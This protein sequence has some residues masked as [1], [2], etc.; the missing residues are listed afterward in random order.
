[1]INIQKNLE[2]L[3]KEKRVLRKQVATALGVSQQ[4]LSNWFNRSTDL[5]FS[6]I[7]Q[8]CEVGGFSVIDAVTWPEKYVPESQAKPNCDECRRKDEVIDNL[9]ELLRKYKQEK[10]QKQ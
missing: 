9:N 6:Q 5:S 4:T 7:T 8:I 2:A 10:Q 1:M 3:L